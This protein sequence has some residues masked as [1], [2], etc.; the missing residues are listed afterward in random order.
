[1]PIIRDGITWKIQS[2][3]SVYPRIDPW[4]GCG[5]AHRLPQDLLLHLSNSSISLIS[6][7]ADQEHTT[8]FQHAWKSAQRIP[9]TWHNHWNQYIVALTELNTRVT[10]G[11]DEIIWA[12]ANNVLYSPK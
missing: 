7:I 10:E 6:H 4:I 8:I 1:M 9:P 11:E 12:H 2:I 5:N 3:T